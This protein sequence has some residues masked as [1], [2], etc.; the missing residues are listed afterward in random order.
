MKLH[1]HASVENVLLYGFSAWI[2]LNLLRIGSAQLIVHE[3]TRPIGEA[4]ASTV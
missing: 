3:R 2:F 4:I 1:W